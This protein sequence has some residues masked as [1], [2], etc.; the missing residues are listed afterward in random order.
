MGHAI[1]QALILAV[2]DVIV[3]DVVP[4]AANQANAGVREAGDS[5]VVHFKT[6]VLRGDAVRGGELVV[7]LVSVAGGSERAPVMVEV[8]LGIGAPDP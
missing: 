3:V 7:V 8:L 5:A 2:V 1:T 4:V 6:G